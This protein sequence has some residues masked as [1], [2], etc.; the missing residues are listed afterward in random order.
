[1][2]NTM[3]KL[4]LVFFTVA[5]VFSFIACGKSGTP[6][7]TAEESADAEWKRIYLEEL[8]AA[9]TYSAAVTADWDK[10]FDPKSKYPSRLSGAQLA[11]LNFDGIPELFLFDPGAG[12]SQFV[13]ILTISSGGTPIIF[14]GW[15]NMGHINL[16]HG[17]GDDILAYCFISANGDMESYS[18]LYYF[19]NE[20]TK[21]DNTFS[22]EA[23]RTSFSE[24]RNYDDNL[25]LLGI[26]YTFGRNEKSEDEYN[27]LKSEYD[28]SLGGGYKKR[29]WPSFTLTWNWDSD[30]NYNYFITL[31]EEQEILE[32]LNSWVPE[33][34]AEG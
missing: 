31:L 23:I 28:E 20:N 19:S 7:K 24:E 22:E 8:L 18:G 2:K 25:N 12:A 5:L 11:D 26:T 6:D 3:K 14:R 21:M 4:F 32:F 29:P 10:S 33:D 15:A 1:M 34:K 17:L 30:K 16:Y 13:H 9:Q 27:R